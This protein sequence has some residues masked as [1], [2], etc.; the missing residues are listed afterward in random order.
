M[1]LREEDLELE[2]IMKKTEFVEVSSTY[3]KTYAEHCIMLSGGKMS[4]A[5][6]KPWVWAKV[7]QKIEAGVYQLPVMIFSHVQ[8][9]LDEYTAG[10]GALVDVMNRARDRVGMKVTV[11]KIYDHVIES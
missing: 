9:T 11:K 3:G 1:G 5:E 7:Y 8:I 6:N 10:T 4:T 2:V